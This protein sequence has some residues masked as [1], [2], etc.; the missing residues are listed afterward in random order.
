MPTLDRWIVKK[1]NDGSKVEPL[2]TIFFLDGESMK[3]EWVREM[4]KL[5]TY[6]VAIKSTLSDEGV[7]LVTNIGRSET[8]KFPHFVL[9][10]ETIYNNVPY[11]KSH[12]QKCIRRS[13]VNL[14][15]KTA[16]HLARLDLQELLRRLAIIMVED[17][18]LMPEFSTL[19]WITAAVSKGYCLDQKR[20]YWLFGLITKMAL[21]TVRDPIHDL[22]LDDEGTEAESTEGKKA[23][24]VSKVPAVPVVPAVPKVLAVPKAKLRQGTLN[25]KATAATATVTAATPV[26]AATLSPIKPVVPVISK[27]VSSAKSAKRA[28]RAKSVKDRDWKKWKIYKLKDED[29]SVIQSLLFRESYG[30][31]KGDKNMLI[32]TAWIWFERFSN[33]KPAEDTALSL[34]RQFEERGPLYVSPPEENLRPNEWI[35]AAIDFHVVNNVIMILAD[36]YETLSYEDIKS[37]I[38][39]NSSKYTNKRDINLENEVDKEKLTKSKRSSASASGDMSWNLIRPEFYS[40][41]SYF[42]KNNH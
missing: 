27:K 37:A 34:Y 42:L 28:E 23:E 18:I 24:K 39:H 26:A 38:W 32:D 4:P 21:V 40:L 41:A 17:A 30:G 5:N 6:S 9:P 12:L 13:N 11:L 36:K 7:T 19:V 1:D 22:S 25:Y 2:F 29:K 35:Q 15:L 31:M 8:D 33:G 10:S 14:A 3:A 16:L 20:M